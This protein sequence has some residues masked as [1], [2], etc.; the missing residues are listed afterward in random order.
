[1]GDWQP[2]AE[3][4]AWR[5]LYHIGIAIIHG[6]VEVF[7]RYAGQTDGTGGAEGTGRGWTVF[8]YRRGSDDFL[9]YNKAEL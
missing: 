2:S 8:L 1:M 7:K 9:L 5:E 4:G 6:T 3:F